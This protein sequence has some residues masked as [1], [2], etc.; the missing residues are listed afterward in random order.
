MK[1]LLT[2]QT[3]L[4]WRQ[5]TNNQQNHINIEWQQR[6]HPSGRRGWVRARVKH[7]RKTET[8]AELFCCQWLKIQEWGGNICNVTGFFFPSLFDIMKHKT[9]STAETARRNLLLRTRP[10]T[11]GD[12]RC[13]RWNMVRPRQEAHISTQGFGPDRK[14]NRSRLDR[15]DKNKEIWIPT[16]NDDTR[17]IQSTFNQKLQMRWRQRTD[18]LKK[19]F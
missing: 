4:K 9:G 7:Q 11:S 5:K 3:N 12:Q 19:N 16:V 8:S 10:T 13:T 2:F 14:S 6:A 1:F 18:K 15:D 17:I